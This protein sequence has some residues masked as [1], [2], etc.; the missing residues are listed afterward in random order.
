MK[1]VASDD[2]ALSDTNVNNNGQSGQIN[3]NDLNYPCLLKLFHYTRAD[4]PEEHRRLV[5]LL[6]LNHILIWIVEI[7]NIIANIAATA[8]G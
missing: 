8:S 7:L 3:W 6:W 2:K 1:Y 5:F 4:V